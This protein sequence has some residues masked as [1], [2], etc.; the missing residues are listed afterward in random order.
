MSTDNLADLSK[1]D[2][3]KIIGN[4][5]GELTKLNE[6]FRK[7]TNLRLYHLER[8]HNMSLQ[9]NRRESFEIAGIPTT[10]SSDALEDE[11]IE[12]CKEAKVSVNRLPL[13]KNDIAAVHRLKDQKTTIVRVV[14]RKFS[15][16]ALY[17]SKNLRNS[18]RYGEGTKIYINNS[19]CPEFKFLFYAIRKAARDGVINRWKIRNGVISIRMDEEDTFHEVG[20]VLDLEN[21]GV[22]IPERRTQVRQ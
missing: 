2:L 15:K 10:V 3:I 22:P 9:Y 12:I 8:S 11:V 14:N 19:F 18:K 5:K 4:L 20:H 7:V 13:K 1:D 17:C 21:L 6:D 16:E